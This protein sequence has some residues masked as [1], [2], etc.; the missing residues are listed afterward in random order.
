MIFLNR[1]YDKKKVKVRSA[2]KKL[3]LFFAFFI[4]C[5]MPVSATFAEIKE[6]EK[7]IEEIVGKNQSREQV[8]AFALQKA[9]RLLWRRQA[10]IFLH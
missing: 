8:E 5:I 10:P 9:K 2:S 3:R 1:T 4:I 7:E 6:F